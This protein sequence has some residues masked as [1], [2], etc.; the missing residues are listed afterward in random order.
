M[1]RVRRSRSRSGLGLQKVTTCSDISVI[2]TNI[3]SD[4]KAEHDKR[5]AVLEARVHAFDKVA[6][7]ATR[8]SQRMDAMEGNVHRFTGALETFLGRIR[9][10]DRLRLVPD[11]TRIEDAP[12]PVHLAITRSASPWT[13]IDA[14][15]E[16]DEVASSSAQDTR[17]TPSDIHGEIRMVEVRAVES[18]PDTVQD[19][20]RPP[21][22]LPVS[23]ADPAPLPTPSAV[24]APAPAPLVNV[25][26][27]TPQGSHNLVAPLPTPVLPPPPLPT[28]P[29]APRIPRSRSRTPAPALLGVE[30][31]RTT[32]S[33][34]RSK[35]PT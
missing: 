28:L 20:D 10:D 26:P 23:T 31:G 12:S 1:R 24:P 19:T 5:L 21:V 11:T 34:S 27:A 35:P 13:P 9:I 30:E 17:T 4:F 29:P 8:T 15:M 22:S 33:R 7:E 2:A 32:R 14:P 16:E 6:E 3:V 18:A 25:I